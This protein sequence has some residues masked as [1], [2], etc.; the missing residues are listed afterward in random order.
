MRRTDLYPASDFRFAN[1]GAMQ[2]PDFR[3]VHGRGCRPTEPL[4]VLPCMRQAGPGAFLQNLPFESSENGKH[5]SHRP[6]SRRRQ[7]QRFGQGNETD[8]QMLQFLKRG[9]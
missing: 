7:V 6:S 3:S 9:E 1:A 2:F 5:G 8:T 4:S